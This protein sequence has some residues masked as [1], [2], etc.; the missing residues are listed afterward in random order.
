[1]YIYPSYKSPLGEI[2]QSMSYDGCHFWLESGVR[3]RLAV[4]HFRP[5]RTRHVQHTMDTRGRAA[6]L[7]QRLQYF[8]KT[9]QGS[10]RLSRLDM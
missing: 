10:T 8:H 1:M 2:Q 7:V 9:G 3:D 4:Y 5:L 6:T